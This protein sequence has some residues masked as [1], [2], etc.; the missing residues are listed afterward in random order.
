MPCWTHSESFW[1]AAT[2]QTPFSHHRDQWA[3]TQTFQV[4]TGL[5]HWNAIHLPAYSSTTTT[6]SVF[7]LWEEFYVLSTFPC[8]T[9]GAGRRKSCSFS[10]YQTSEKGFF[11]EHDRPTL[12]K[13]YQQFQ[14]VSLIFL[15]LCFLSVFFASAVNWRI[16]LKD[17][18][19]KIGR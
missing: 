14:G 7:P 11:S 12:F 4:E 3:E 9:K 10:D 18:R 2:V 1:K 6:G 8:G 19:R 15:Y 17:T 16:R 5:W 13:H